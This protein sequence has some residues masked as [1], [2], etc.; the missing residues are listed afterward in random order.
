MSGYLEQYGAGEERKEHLIRNAIFLALTV[1]ILG[2]LALYLLHT[3]HQVRVANRFLGQLRAGDYTSAYAAWGCSAATPC[4]EYSNEKFMEDWGPKS[5]AA[6]GSGVHVTD[7]ESCGTGVII[8]LAGG[9][10]P[11]Q[12]LYVGKDSDLLSF[13]PL[14]TCP[15]K[16]AWAIMAHRTLGRMRRIFY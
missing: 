3:F 13:S 5:P 16:S 14:P 4:K 10:G 11:Q 6:G 9:T 8:S 2:A 1:I 7:S 15:G 12:K